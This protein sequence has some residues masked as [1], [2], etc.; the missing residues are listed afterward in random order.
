MSPRAQS[1]PLPFVLAGAVAGTVAAGLRASGSRRVAGAAA[2]GLVGWA[3]W[4]LRSPRVD[5]NVASRPGPTTQSLVL[6][7]PAD[8]LIGPPGSNLEQR[9]DEAIHETFPASDPIA[10]CI[11]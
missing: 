7:S 11:E 5:A 8:T 6:F 10:I 1:S 3:A 4:A 2:G 9:L